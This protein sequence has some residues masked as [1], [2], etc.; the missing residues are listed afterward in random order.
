MRYCF[1]VFSLL[2]LLTA[3]PTAGQCLSQWHITVWPEGDATIQPRQILLFSAGANTSA[4]PNLPQ[5]GRQIQVYL[6]SRHDSVPLLLLDQP[7]NPLSSDLQVLM[8][9]ARP[10]LPDTVYYLRT[11]LP[12]TGYSLFRMQRARAGSKQLVIAHHW[13]VSSAPPD[14]QAP[15]WV[16]TPTV[17]RKEYSENSEGINNYVLFSYPVQD[18][19]LVLVRATIRSERLEKPNVSYLKSWQNQ[20]GIGWFTCGGDFQFASGEEYTVLFEALDAAGNRSQATG[21]PIPF[22]S[23]SRPRQKPT[24]TSTR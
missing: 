24:K 4:H 20:L 16:A 1:Y 22:R 3:R 17:V 18:S 5:F 14:T 19:S 23:P 7:V 10:L 6:W 9:P 8:Q 21:H 13:R 15:R 12:P 2:L 11:S